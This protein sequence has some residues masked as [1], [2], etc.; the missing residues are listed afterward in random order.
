[1][2]IL[3][4]QEKDKLDK[5]FKQLTMKEKV[6]LEIQFEKEQGKTSTLSHLG[7]KYEN[8]PIVFFSWKPHLFSLDS[9]EN[10]NLDHPIW[11]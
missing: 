4:S 6:F 3:N 10:E 1:M 5:S 2:K 8:Q 9:K 11:I 7:H